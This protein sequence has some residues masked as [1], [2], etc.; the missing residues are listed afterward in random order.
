MNPDAPCAAPNEPT[1]ARL[2]IDDVVAAA[3]V[4][5]AAAAPVDAILTNTHTSVAMDESG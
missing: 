3:I 4:A 2:S 5:P 1:V